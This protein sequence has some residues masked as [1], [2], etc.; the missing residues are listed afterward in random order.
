VPRERPVRDAVTDLEPAGTL[1]FLR[2]RHKTA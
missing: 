2:S 1:P